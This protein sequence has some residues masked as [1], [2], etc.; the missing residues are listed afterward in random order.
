MHAWS[1]TRRGAGT[2]CVSRRSIR[3]Q[4]GDGEVLLRVRRRVG[5]TLP[6]GSSGVEIAERLPLAEA[7]R[8]QELSET[9]HGRG[10][11]VLTVCA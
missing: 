3:P 7:R 9:G 11:I 4:P 10:K 5:E 6:T 1:R 2:S 8:A